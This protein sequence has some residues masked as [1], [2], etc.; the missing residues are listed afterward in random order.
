[1]YRGSQHIEED[2]DLNWDGNGGRW[3]FFSLSFLD[4]SENYDWC[5]EN[6]YETLS[7]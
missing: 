3:Y 5:I 2:S 7:S 6:G 1:M 4:E